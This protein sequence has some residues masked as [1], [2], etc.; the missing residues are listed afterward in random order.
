MVRRVNVPVDT[1]KMMTS[2]I[3][4][5]APA[6]RVVNKYVSDMLKATPEREA[7]LAVNLA[8]TWPSA[9]MAVRAEVKR[10]Q[11]NQRQIE[12]RQIIKAREKARRANAQRLAEQF[13]AED[14]AADN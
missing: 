2:T 11:K 7:A 3:R 14:N 4:K 12:L 10:R 6:A 13:R 9:W 5:T 8:L 1:V